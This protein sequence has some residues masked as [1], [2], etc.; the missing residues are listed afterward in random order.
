VNRVDIHHHILP[1]AYVAK[2]RERIAAV[3]GG[4]AEQVLSWTPQRSIA[5]MD[6]AGVQMAITSISSP[7][8]DFGDA[9]TLAR[10]CN[11]YAAE[12]AARHAG[13][14][15]VFAVLPMPDVDASLKEMDRARNVQGF[16]LYTNYGGAW[17][18]DPRFTPVLEEMN[19]RKAVVFVHPMV[20]PQCTDMLA[21][22]PDAIMEYPFDTTRT[23]ASLLYSG[24]FARHKDIRFIFTHGGGALPM[25]AHRITRYAAGNAAEE[26]KRLYFDVVSVTQPGPFAALKAL[27]PTTQLLFG[28]DYP[29]WP[30]DLTAKGLA[31]LGLSDADKLAIE[32]GNA[33]KI[34]KLEMEKAL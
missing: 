2:A 17:L 3:A 14:F 20:C 30:P 34:L 5:A 16:G 22:V 7:G 11:D 18:G 8:V 23:I 32:G 33:R 15:G 28:S 31:A 24:A 25:L 29:Y 26:L 6:Q 9:T 1:P 19:R 13:R 21:G 10:E 4:F 12:M 27:V